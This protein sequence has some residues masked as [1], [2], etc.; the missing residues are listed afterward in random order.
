M[1]YF[2]CAILFLL[3]SYLIRFKIFGIPTN[4]LETLIIA[5]L[6]ILLFKQIKE[7]KFADWIK[8][9]ISGLHNEKLFFF[10]VTLIFAGIFLSS[11]FAQ[12]K[13][14]AFGIFKGWLIIPFIFFLVLYQYLRGLPLKQK[15]DKIRLLITSLA[16]SGLIYL[17]AFAFT[18][19]FETLYKIKID[20]ITFD[21]RL[22]LFF[23]SP[24][25]LAMAL[26]PLIFAFF[27]LFSIQ[28]NL[29]K[30]MTYFNL[31]FVFIILLFLTKSLGAILAIFAAFIIY[32]AITKFSK[33]NINVLCFKNSIICSLFFI[34]ILS[35]L[36]PVIITSIYNPSV[37]DRSSL[38]S[39][40]MIWQSAQAILR[41]NYFAGIGPGNFQDK[42]LDYQKNF[43]PY[44][45][46]AVPHPHNTFLT[47]W[48]SGGILAL[49][50]FLL[51]IFWAISNLT[52]NTKYEILYTIYFIIHSSV[53]T[54]YFK[55]DLS[56]MFW[57]LIALILLQKITNQSNI[58]SIKSS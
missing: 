28:K 58:K 29:V 54:L 14:L 32:L 45:E 17:A 44:L 2:L 56:V 36:L 35:V 20:F 38:A 31:M 8:K 5:A 39:R 16:M 57:F 55:N 26:A 49:I 47:F 10:A 48:T 19:L 7:G 40:I 46:W 53:D 23:D 21:D 34:L 50:G 42:Y 4:F 24:N 18:P 15:E 9:I 41:D 6:I 11:F 30:K 43:S 12:N 33:F 1:F 25:Q 22:R 52:L 3:P 27:Y 13:L 37:K 51:L